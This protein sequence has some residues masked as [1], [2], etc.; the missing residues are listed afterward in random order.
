MDASAYIGRVGGLAVALGVGAAVVLGSPG[1]AF[2]TTDTEPTSQTDDG[3]SANT[4]AA[5]QD[6]P[7]QTESAQVADEQVADE[8]DV[9]D[10]EADDAEAEPQDVTVDPEDSM[11]TDPEETD[12]DGTTIEAEPVAPAPPQ[13]FARSRDRD[14]EP[15]APEPPK[16]S[17]ASDSAAAQEA[18]TLSA[19]A[20]EPDTASFGADQPT[21]Q[22]LAALRGA[23]A[24]DVSELG[25]TLVPQT[26]AVVTAM[27]APT[28]ARSAAP[29]LNRLLA[30]FGLGSLRHLPALPSPTWAVSA[31]MALASRREVDRTLAT[32]SV[33]TS[34]STVALAAAAAPYDPAKDY[35]VTPVTVSGNTVRITNVTGPGGLNNTT[36]R[37]GI[38]GTDLG[39]MWDN[40]IRDNPN[41]AVNEHQVLIAFGD[42]FSNRT[43]VRTGIWRMNTLFRSTD[44]KLSN[45]MYVA[46]GIPHDPGMY[47]GSPMS[48]P[49]F[50]RE[51]IGNYHYGIGPEVTM[52]PTAAISVPGAG[53]D[54]ATRQYINYMAVKSWDTPGRWT[55]NYS[56]IAYSDDNGQNWTVVPQSSVR[57]AA[58]GR[59][60]LPFVNGDQNFQ[61][62]AYVRKYTV[63]PVTGKPLKDAAGREITDGYIYSYGTPA[64]RA[65]TAYVSRVAEADILDKTKYEYWNGTSWTPGN[66]AAAKPILPSTTTTSFFGLVRTTTYPTVSEMSVQY[67]SYEKKY[68]MLYG[69][70]NNNI[71][72]RKADSPEGPWSAP[73]TLVTASKM[74]G[75]YA[76]MIHPWSS[77]EN[78]SPEE[79]QYLYWNLSTWDD[80]QVKLMRTDLTKV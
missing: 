46:D 25:Q 65:G 80:Y 37:F 32:R 16:V 5:E 20:E 47:S 43:P 61:Q 15:A 18:E 12:P 14:H 42:T 76:P 74:P 71:V 69:D 10:I 59:T 17:E 41:T 4:P 51:I 8:Q 79:Q 67:N 50:S 1:A 9:D 33:S 2:A 48:D 22:P 27:T 55:T 73:V 19:T 40:G 3:D 68:I 78:L 60:T 7:R 30:A 29:V 23:V 56:A 44:T 70:K 24:D 6:S 39:I 62:G 13:S 53:E 28:A 57:P 77:T 21:G 75:L 58:A 36:S 52:I 54:G 26:A 35:V 66:P 63:D 64:G 31:L 38:G 34:Q 72:M 49:N 11:V 45:G